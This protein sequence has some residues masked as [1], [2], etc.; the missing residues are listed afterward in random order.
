MGPRTSYQSNRLHWVLLMSLGASC[1]LRRLWFLGCLGLM[2]V[3]LVMFFGLSPWEVGPSALK[4]NLAQIVLYGCFLGF[5]ASV[6]GL[7]IWVVACVISFFGRHV[8]NDY[9]QGT[10]FD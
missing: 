1:D 4:S 5:C 7:G 6:S 9:R 2:A 3:C 10:L 8:K